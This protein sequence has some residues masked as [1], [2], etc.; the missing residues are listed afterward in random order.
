MIDADA[1][2]KEQQLVAKTQLH[3]ALRS[4]SNNELNEL[5][6]IAEHILFNRQHSFEETSVARRSDW[7]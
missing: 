5:I 6:S 2:V 7:L 4:M 3:F 1:F